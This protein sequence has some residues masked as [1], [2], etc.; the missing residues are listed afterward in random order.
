MRVEGSGWDRIRARVLHCC[1]VARDVDL[2]VLDARL[3]RRR[4]IPVSER[5]FLIDNLLVR[6]H[7]TIV[8][9]WWTG[10]AP[11]KFELPFLGSFTSTFPLWIKTLSI[12]LVVCDARLVRRSNVK[13]TALNL[14]S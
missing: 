2:V 9:I 11:R 6:I 3:V 12:D 10:L 7:F 13:K 1:E 8:I 14:P 5:E 4:N